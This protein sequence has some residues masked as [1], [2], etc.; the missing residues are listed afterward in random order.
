MNLKTY[1]F[2]VLFLI[3]TAVPCLIYSDCCDDGFGNMPVTDQAGQDEDCRGECS[4]LTQCGDCLTWFIQNNILIPSVNS[5]V[6]TFSSSIIN[7]TII[8]IP[9]EIFRPPKV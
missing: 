7:Q 9:K 5:P 8:L 3:G 4:P 1:I 6:K 2:S